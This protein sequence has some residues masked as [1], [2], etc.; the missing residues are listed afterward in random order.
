MPFDPIASI[1]GI[2]T[3]SA[4]LT[5]GLAVGYSTGPAVSMDVVG[6]ASTE[7]LVVGT[8]TISVPMVRTLMVC[9]SVAST[10]EV[11]SVVEMKT[12]MLVATT[13]VVEAVIPDDASISMLPPPT[14][15]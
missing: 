12:T 8:I 9:D 7:V 10:F 13:P 14:A 15:S 3:S 4:S 11:D 2:G 5:M 1:G 6:I